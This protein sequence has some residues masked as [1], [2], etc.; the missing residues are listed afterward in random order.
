MI[1]V[2]VK[3]F[4]ARDGIGRY[5]NIIPVLLMRKMRQSSSVS[6]LGKLGK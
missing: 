6:D 4:A 5:L 3:Y 1:S 2:L